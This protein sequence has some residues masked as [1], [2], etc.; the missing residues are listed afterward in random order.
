MVTPQPS[1]TL[2]PGA[3]MS[4]FDLQG[5]QASMWHTH[6]HWRQNIPTHKI[7]RI[8]VEGNVA[9]TPI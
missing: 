2:V 5:H 1:I 3:M 8:H 9:L 7:R 4:S 6:I